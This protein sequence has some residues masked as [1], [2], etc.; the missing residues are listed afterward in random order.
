M[1]YLR[2]RVNCFRCNL[3]VDRSETLL[4]SAAGNE[5]KY[6]CHTCY[7]KHSK[8]IWWSG[9]KLKPKLE[10]F[11]GRCKY[12]FQSKKFICPYCSK[13]DYVEERN[14]SIHDLI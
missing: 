11:C 2:A 4:L 6:E 12:G 9:D 7:K 5:R 14:V 10:L 13:P 8:Q 1:V 3:P